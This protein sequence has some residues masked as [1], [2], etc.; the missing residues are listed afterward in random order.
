MDRARFVDTDLA[1]RIAETVRE[2]TSGRLRG[3]RVTVAEDVV[4]VHGV[5]PSF[6][7]KQLVVEAVR[8]A[9]HGLPFRFRLEI[10]VHAR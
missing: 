7:L 1:D 5:V 9:L 2:R 4:T 3:T 6:H 8:A 10:A